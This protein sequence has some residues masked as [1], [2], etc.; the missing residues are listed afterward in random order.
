M[1]EIPSSQ[2]TDFFPELKKREKERFEKALAE[3]REVVL[4]NHFPSL[5]DASA[6]REYQGLLSALQ[7]LISLAA[8]IFFG[9]LPSPM[10]EI[11]G[12]SA[13]EVYLSGL[14]Y[15][16]RRYPRGYFRKTVIALKEW[17]GFP[18]KVDAYSGKCLTGFSDFADLAR[19]LQRYA[20]N[21]KSAKE[22]ARLYHPADGDAGAKEGEDD[23]DYYKDLCLLY[24]SLKTWE[25]EEDVRRFQGY[26][27]KSATQFFEVI[28]EGPIQLY[29]FIGEETWF[30]VLKV[31]TVES[32]GDFLS[33]KNRKELQDLRDL[34]RF[35]F[36]AIEQAEKWQVFKELIREAL[37]GY[38]RDFRSSE[39]RLRAQCPT[40]EL[41]R[42]FVRRFESG[43]IFRKEG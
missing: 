6:L 14:K 13:W 35:I 19:E 3:A 27:E 36:G 29:F 21:Y 1:S 37:A 20:L 41:K 16:T 39:K 31:L 42:K 17:E 43:D 38:V 40:D 2:E 9:L 24:A 25:R 4:K 12:R 22:L 7:A 5:T 28:I 8:G 10:E 11:R 15:L 30:F 34:H 32:L 33:D 26:L 23:A 18:E